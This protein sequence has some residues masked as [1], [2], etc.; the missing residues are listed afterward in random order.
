MLANFQMAQF[1]QVIIYLFYISLH[2]YRKTIQALAYPISSNT[3]HNFQLF[4]ATSPTYCYECEGL[5]WGVARQG[6]RCTECGV[7]CHDK[8]KRLLNADCLQSE[9]VC[10]K[11]IIQASHTAQA[12]LLRSVSSFCNIELV[13]DELSNTTC[14]YSNRD[15]IEIRQTIFFIS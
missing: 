15:E 9:C 3:P 12:R 10:F 8:C 14:V 2:V 13:E 6:L 7:K 4:T 1:Q 5:L 11:L